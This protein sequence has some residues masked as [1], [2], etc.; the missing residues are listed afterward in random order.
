MKAIRIYQFGDPDVMQLEDVPDPVVGAGQVLIRVCASGVNPLD[1][2]LRAGAK[3]GDYTPTL[4]YTP[5]N[6][7]AGVVIAVGEG[8]TRVTVG[9]RVYAQPLTGSYAE[10]ALCNESQV[11]SLPPKISF[12]EGTAINVPCRTA[13]YSLF[14]LAK[15]TPGEIVL[16]HGA[17]GSVGTA[18]VQLAAAA[19]LTVIGTASSE[20]GLQLVKDLGAQYSFNHRHPDYLAQIATVTNSHGIDVILEMAANINLTKDLTLMAPGGRI[21]I[22]GGQGDVAVDPVSIIGLGLSIMGVRLSSADEKT[23]EAIHEALSSSLEQGKLRPVVAQEIPLA[24]AARAH[25]EIEQSG[26]MGRICLIP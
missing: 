21:I 15:S 18:A 12:A 8:V 11:Y 3:I 25:R 13:Y 6:D 14:T 9:D 5:G 1:T 2:Y 4:P 19:G 16:I 20:P 17:S 23:N 10:L 22:I 24:E 7:A 26:T